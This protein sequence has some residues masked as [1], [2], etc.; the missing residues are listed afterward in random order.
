MVFDQKLM[1]GLGLAQ[2]STRREWVQGVLS[3]CGLGVEFPIHTVA[4]LLALLGIIAFLR[5]YPTLAVF[6]F[7]AWIIP[8]FSGS[9][10]SLIRYML[11]SPTTFLFLG[12]SD[13]TAALTVH[14][15]SQVSC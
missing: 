1:G 7:C 5:K 3:R 4:V 12:N 11:V 9:P 15:L 8:V 13:T 14:G 6:S 2:S 10:Q